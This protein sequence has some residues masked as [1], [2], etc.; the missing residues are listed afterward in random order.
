NGRAHAEHENDNAA[1]DRELFHRAPSSARRHGAPARETLTLNDPALSPKT[2]S[3]MPRNSLPSFGIAIGAC[4]LP[5]G[6]GLPLEPTRPIRPP[7]PILPGRPS[8]P[9]GPDTWSGFEPHW[10]VPSV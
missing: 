3:L 10:I 1:A 9:S 7:F 4:A 8:W 2:K 6:N 5:I